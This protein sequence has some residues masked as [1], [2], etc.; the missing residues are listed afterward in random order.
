VVDRVKTY[1]DYQIFTV[2]EAKKSGCT[3]RLT[4]NFELPSEER[5]LQNIL[6]DMERAEV[7][8]KIVRNHK[9]NWKERKVVQIWRTEPKGLHI[10]EGRSAKRKIC[11][12]NQLTTVNV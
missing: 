10:V 11:K 1:K 8:C 5:L 4:G 7:K 12:V 6:K 2:Y 3:Y 9:H